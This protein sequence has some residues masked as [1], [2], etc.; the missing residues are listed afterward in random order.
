MATTGDGF[1]A[2]FD[3]PG[4][5]VTCAAEVAEAVRTLGIDVRVG[6]HTGEIEL[7][8]AGIGGI[9]VHIAQRVMS[10]ADPGRILVS[11]TVKDLVVGSGI[12]FEDRGYARAE[13]RARRVGPLRGE[14]GPVTDQ[15]RPARLKR[16]VASA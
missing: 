11:R 5:A 10:A 4:R 12:E 2:T 8:D 3:G 13:G 16:P 14:L 6:L 7:R 1:L 9:A 15:I